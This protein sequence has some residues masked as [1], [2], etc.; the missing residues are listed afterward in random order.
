MPDFTR[1]RPELVSHISDAFGLRFHRCR[2]WCLTKNA[3]LFEN[4]TTCRH[5][6]QVVTH[7]V[8]EG[9]LLADR[10]RSSSKMTLTTSGGCSAPQLLARL[11]HCVG[12]LRGLFKRESSESVVFHLVRGRSA[13]G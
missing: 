11:R 2:K 3:G 13:A 1:A 9:P 5:M 8:T 10:N 6:L 12:E 4:A 7:P